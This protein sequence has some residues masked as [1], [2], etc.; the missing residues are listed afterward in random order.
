MQGQRAAEGGA[1]EEERRRDEGTEDRAKE[2]ARTAGGII[3]QQ[4]LVGDR[5]MRWRFEGRQRQR[6]ARVG[7]KEHAK[8]NG[9]GGYV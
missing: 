3:R 9:C 2:V 1:G 6:A 8:G 7:G 4:E 5:G